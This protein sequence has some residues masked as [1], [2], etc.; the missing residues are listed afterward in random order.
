M[1][2][3]ELLI[4]E[5]E[6]FIK[7]PEEDKID[8][9]SYT[10]DMDIIKF[11]LG[12]DIEEIR[13]AVSRNSYINEND[14]RIL[15]DDASEFVRKNV[16][17]H[18]KSPL[19]ILRKLSKDKSKEV[20]LAVAMN[21]ETSKEILDEMLEM[22]GKAF[23][24]TLKL[25]EEEYKNIE[26]VYDIIVRLNE[27]N[28]YYGTVTCFIIDEIEKIGLRPYRLRDYLRVL[29]KAERIVEFRPDN[30]IPSEYLR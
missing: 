2:Q 20:R 11:G 10:R 30:Y 16:A 5:Y 13:C 18:H 29:I 25:R 4:M 8:I 19:D 21:F 12:S 17:S 7:L 6:E 27:E 14:L 26:K 9:L 28:E 15:S 1:K 3:N 24:E 22:E 23:N